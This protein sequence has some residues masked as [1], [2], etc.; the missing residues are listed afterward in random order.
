MNLKDALAKVDDLLP[1]LE[2]LLAPDAMLA[3]RMVY[4]AASGSAVANMVREIER[5]AASVPG[6]DAPPIGPV[7]LGAADAVTTPHLFVGRSGGTCYLCPHPRD[8]DIHPN[9]GTP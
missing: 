1:A 9:R 8:H 2:K 3:F 4:D 7:Y 5:E 6:G